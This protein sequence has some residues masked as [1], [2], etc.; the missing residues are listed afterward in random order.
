MRNYSRRCCF[1]QIWNEDNKNDENFE[2]GTHKYYQIE[3]FVNG[4]FGDFTVE[5]TMISYIVKSY[6]EYYR[7]YNSYSNNLT[8]GYQNE[9]GKV[10][11]IERPCDA[12]NET[13]SGSVLMYILYFI[14]LIS[15]VKDK[16][17]V[18]NIC[19]LLFDCSHTL[20]LG[21]SIET[22]KSSKELFQRI[23]EKYPFMEEVINTPLEKRK[24]SIKEEL[25]QA[26]IIEKIIIN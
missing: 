12:S 13:G 22:I 19:T 23:K 7:S 26:A 6:T 25:Y 2:Y 15:E 24:E 20:G 14:I 5:N 8:I 4:L 10:F 11:F 18:Q 21:K 3:L 16:E 17:K 1:C 9:F